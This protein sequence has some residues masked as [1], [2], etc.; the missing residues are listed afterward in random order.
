MAN[1]LLVDD[2]DEILEA[3]RAC[4][5]GQGFA[6]ECADT[7]VKALA[8]LNE[9]RYDCIVLD[10]LLPDL[11]GIAICKAARTLTDA[12]ILFLSCLEETADKVKGLSAGGD[13]Y[14]AKPYSLEEFCARVRALMRRGERLERDNLSGSF[15]IDRENRLIH[16]L[17]KTVFL[18]ER[19]FMLFELLHGNP[20]VQFSNEN[21][22]KD[23]WQGNAGISVVK[24]LAS[25][26]RQ[27]IEF[28]EEVL[29]RVTTSYG[30]GYCLTPPRSGK[31]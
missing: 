26:L 30:V 8:A 4:L 11:D 9:K 2:N 12:P 6:V 3:N 15:Y 20:G 16:A 18:T 29:G 27:K 14:M 19:E 7:G 22:L 17:G 21:L 1:I 25:R 23:I 13:D 31:Q 24:A 28:A 5:A 10:I